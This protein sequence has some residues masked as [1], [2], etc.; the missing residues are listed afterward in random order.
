MEGQSHQSTIYPTLL[1]FSGA[2]K[3]VFSGSVYLSTHSL[4]TSLCVHFPQTY[5]QKLSSCLWTPI[6]KSQQGDSDGLSVGEVSI[7]GPVSCG[8]EVG[9]VVQTWLPALHTGGLDCPSGVVPGVGQSCPLS[10]SVPDLYSMVSRVYHLECF[11]LQV[12]EYSTNRGL[13]IKSFDFLT[14]QVVFRAGVLGLAC[15]SAWSSRSR[16]FPSLLFLC[17]SLS[18]HDCKR[19]VAAP[20]ITPSQG[21]IQ[22]RKQQSSPPAS[23]FFLN[24]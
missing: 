6:L 17:L 14:P 11:Q 21:P 10:V 20:G 23:I 13:T 22:S 3:S 8:R 16:I 5:M 12:T 1:S 19:A 2:I 9:R 15:G 7:P 4:P 24:P 18:L